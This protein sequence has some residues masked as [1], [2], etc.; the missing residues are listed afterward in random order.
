MD[1][2]S[3]LLILSAIITAFVISY[4]SMPVII[5]IA[6]MK[7]LIDAPDG[8]R[9]L[10]KNIIPT[11]G[12]IGIFSAFIISFSIWGQAGG[13][14]SYPY[15]T[16]SLFMLFLIGVKDDILVLSPLKKLLVQI[17]ASAL[18][19]Y[20]GNIAITSFGGLFGIHDLHPWGSFI[21]SVI[22]MVAIINSFNLIDGIDGLAGG[23]GVVVSGIFGI[24]FWGAGFVSLSVLS[25]SLAAALLGFLTFNMHPAKIFMGDTGSMAVGFILGYMTIQF[26]TLNSAMQ[27]MTGYVPNAHIFSIAVLIIPIIDTLRVFIIR[28]LN[29]QNPMIADRNHTHHVLLAIGMSPHHASFIL[30]IF[31]ILIIGIAYQLAQINVNLQLAIVLLAGVL[32]LPIIKIALRFNKSV[33]FSK[34]N[35]KSSPVYDS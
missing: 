23:I 26:V 35:R 22:V 7:N 16:A 10:H 4:I 20:G 2:N 14:E 18:I 32:I 28:L 30:W 9:K 5:R 1:L 17:V 25:F 12:G 24:W 27:G 29:G 31:N 3:L 8:E 19:V 6:E 13:L 15:F 21:F 11:L 34:R 33:E